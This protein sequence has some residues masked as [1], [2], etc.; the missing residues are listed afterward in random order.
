MRPAK[1]VAYYLFYLWGKPHKA[2]KLC[3]HF[4]AGAG[5]QNTGS[6]KEDRTLCLRTRLKI[7]GFATGGA[8]RPTNEQTNRRDS[9]QS[10]GQPKQTQ[11]QTKS[12]RKRRQT[13]GKKRSKE[14]GKGAGN[15]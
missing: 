12:Q 4:G 13:A 15:P 3:I 6:E 8:D 7:Y 11:G 14:V 2:K 10:D 9:R 1:L 5:E